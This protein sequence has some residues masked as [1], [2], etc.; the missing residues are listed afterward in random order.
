[1]DVKIFSLLLAVTNGH[2]LFIVINLVHSLRIIYC[3]SLRYGVNII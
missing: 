2:C 3:K 1:M